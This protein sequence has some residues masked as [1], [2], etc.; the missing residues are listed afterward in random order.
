MNAFFNYFGLLFSYYKA[1]HVVWS[2][3]CHLRQ[4]ISHAY[5]HMGLIWVRFRIMLLWQS[6]VLQWMIFFLTLP[7]EIL[8]RPRWNSRKK[9]QMT[10]CIGLQ[11]DERCGITAVPNASFG[12]V[13]HSHWWCSCQIFLHGLFSYGALGAE[14][15]KFSVFVD[16]YLQLPLK[17]VI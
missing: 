3:D 17:P 6:L 14:S 16:C 4:G 11:Q 8:K 7:P 13:S 5:I 15:N 10:A 1:V 9:Q 12:P 2:V